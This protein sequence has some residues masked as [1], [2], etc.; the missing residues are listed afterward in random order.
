MV[1]S[2]TNGNYIV[3]FI[4]LAAKQ[5]TTPSCTFLIHDYL[6]KSNPVVSCL[7]VGSYHY[8]SNSN[9]KLSFCSLHTPQWAAIACNNSWISFVV[10]FKGNPLHCTVLVNISSTKDPHYVVQYFPQMKTSR[11][12]LIFCSKKLH[13]E[14]LFSSR[15]L[16]IFRWVNNLKV[17]RNRS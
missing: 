16:Q 4:P 15:F 6:L 12:I 11:Y 14:A 3:N 8:S 2:L 17:I 5:E 10:W 9:P 1:Y 7:E 13:K